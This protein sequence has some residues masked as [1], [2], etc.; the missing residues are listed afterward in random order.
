MIGKNIYLKVKGELYLIKLHSYFIL[1]LSSSRLRKTKNKITIDIHQAR[2]NNEIVRISDNAFFRYLTSSLGRKYSQENMTLIEKKL[3]RLKSKSGNGEQ[4]KIL[5]DRI[6]EILY[7]PEIC[8][9]TFDDNRHYKTI[10]EKG[11]YINNI[12][13]KRLLSGAGMARRKTVMFI[14]ESLWD[15]AMDFLDCGRDKSMKLNSSKYSAYVALA[16]SGGLEIPIPRI[17]I[18]PDYEVTRPTEVDFVSANNKPYCDPVIERKII[19][20][21]FNIFDGQGIAN[22]QWVNSVGYQLEWDYCPA[23]MIVRGSF[24]KGLL[25]TMDIPLFAEKNGVSKI[26]DIY[27]KEYDVKDID[28]IMSASQEK[29]S[30]G[31]SSTEQYIEE[32]K[33]RNFNWSV[34]RP[35][36]KENR[37]VSRLTYQYIQ[38]L[39]LDK[40]QIES[41]CEN[42]IN[43]LKNVTGDWLS[44][45]I[46]LVG[47]LD[48]RNIDKK[49][50]DGLDDFVKCLLLNPE[51]IRD[52]YVQNKIRRMVSRKIKDSYQ[53]LVNVPGN[54]QFAISE[55]IAQLQH[56]FGLPI[57]GFLKEGEFYS[58]HWNKEGVNKI[59]LLRSPLT[60]KSEV[61]IGNLVNNDEINDA[62]EYLKSGIVYNI[63]DCAAMRNGGEDFDGDLVLS[64]NQKEVID[65]AGE[66]IP[67]TYER[68]TATKSVVNQEDIWKSDVRTFGTRIGLI[69]N[70]GTTIF[71]MLENYDKNSPEYGILIN[72][73]KFLSSASNMEIDAAKGIE[74]IK[75]PKWWTDWTKITDD[76]TEEEKEICKLNNKLVVQQRPYFMRHV[77]SDKNKEYQKHEKI[78]ENYSINRFGLTMKDLLNKENK[79]EEE[80]K[81]CDFYY[82]YSN[83]INNDSVM[84]Y[85]C[86]YMESN[87]KEMDRYRSDFGWDFNVSDEKYNSMKEIYQIWREHGKNYDDE[88]QG[89]LTTEIGDITNLLGH[90]DNEV[91]RLALSVNSRFAFV[92]FMPKIVELFRK[93]KINVPVLDRNGE[94]KYLGNS[95]SFVEVNI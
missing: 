84:N 53:G 66:S 1:K 5:Q 26:I 60:W 8:N 95:Y 4:I 75:M 73:L 64:T 52:R 55:P 86:K 92:C 42:T 71:S 36:P 87:V 17:V 43:H 89:S 51:I 48:K 83:L 46:F 47:S 12:P 90:S 9:V 62:Y 22:R 58:Q 91:A 15:S 38:V 76:M 11:L 80:Q 34:I 81:H 69:T 29:M 40:S 41:L 24:S 82:R 49:W 70:V 10:V 28:V 14:Q 16:T 85:L 13:Y 50:F 31:Y 74:I 35:A 39:D 21:T 18:I 54:Y 44:S 19:Q 2:L 37:S 65:G 63:H 6:D 57:K 32:C 20:Q 78:Y 68:L 72:R 27:G 77:Y 67:I 30:G 7:I 3:K 33:K 93:E 23:S 94:Y 61:V 88:S 56:A 25:V 45:V 79:S 59:A